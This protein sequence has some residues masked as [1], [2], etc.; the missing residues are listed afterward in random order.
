MNHHIIATSN[1]ATGP[2]I[3]THNCRTIETLQSILPD[4][5]RQRTNLFGWL[6]VSSRHEQR[7]SVLAGP[8]RSVTSSYLWMIPKT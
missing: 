4:E 3:V 2:Y 6:S 1:C 7:T 5:A 8:N